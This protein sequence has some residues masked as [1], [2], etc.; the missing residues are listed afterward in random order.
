MN[1]PTGGGLE[2][3]YRILGLVPGADAGQVKAAYKRL[4]KRWHPD[5]C[6][7]DRR[8]ATRFQKI[9]KAYRTIV[10][11]K[12]RSHAEMFVFLRGLPA[13]GRPLDIVRG[14]RSLAISTLLLSR[15][16]LA[17]IE[18]GA[19]DDAR[20]ILDRIDASGPPLVSTCINR[21]YLSFLTGD[22]SCALENLYRAKDLFGGDPVIALNLSVLLK[23]IGRLSDAYREIEQ[24]ADDAEQKVDFFE[25]M[26]RTVSFLDSRRRVV[27]Q[28]RRAVDDRRLELSVGER[29]SRA[30]PKLTGPM[31]PP[32]R[33]A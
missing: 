12:E 33:G 6:A 29:G 30:V 22:D 9:N 10:G 21:A 15:L 31:A 1:Y 14:Y 11:A 16:A 28:L 18:E 3:H 27:R 2:R 19:V 24:Q 25:E 4:A 5:R 8:A 26:A 13:R 17:Y 23:K 7:G 20:D 32:E